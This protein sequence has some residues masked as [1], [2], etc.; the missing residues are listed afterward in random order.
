VALRD[1]SSLAAVTSNVSTEPA[2]KAGK[3]TLTLLDW[4]TT[5]L[6]R[7]SRHGRRPATAPAVLGAGRLSY[8]LVLAVDVASGRVIHRARYEVVRV[9]IEPGADS[10]IQPSAILVADDRL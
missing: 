7:P 2:G 10:R 6:A 4:V 8:R 1:W 3:A 5:R 9:G